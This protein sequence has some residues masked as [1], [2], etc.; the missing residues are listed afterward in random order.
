MP[1]DRE[2]L[3]Y[4]DTQTIR[5][6]GERV[7]PGNARAVNTR[8]VGYKESPA[9]RPSNTLPPR[10]P[11]YNIGIGQPPIPESRFSR[12]ASGVRIMRGALAARRAFKVQKKG[13]RGRREG[14]PTTSGRCIW[15]CVHS[16]RKCKPIKI[17]MPASFFFSCA[18]RAPSFC[19]RP[20]FAG[21]FKLSLLKL[22]ECFLLGGGGVYL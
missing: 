15:L 4:G 20:G 9:G 14:E 11:P 17:T 8:V 18:R 2:A 7:S 1:P 12:G 16:A 19:A 6:R 21:A 22:T 3:P 5:G 13:G 10:L